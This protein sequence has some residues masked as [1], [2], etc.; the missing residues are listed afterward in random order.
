MFCG[1]KNVGP[2][3]IALSTVCP[4]NN[5][6]D[7]ASRERH[8]FT[9]VRCPIIVIVMILFLFHWYR[10]QDQNPWSKCSNRCPGRLTLG[11]DGSSE[12]ASR[13]DLDAKHFALIRTEKWKYNIYPFLLQGWWFGR[14]GRIQC[15]RDSVGLFQVRVQETIY[16][17]IGF[18]QQ[19][20]LIILFV[21]HCLHQTQEIPRQND[22]LISCPGISP[23]KSNTSSWKASPSNTNTFNS[24]W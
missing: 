19:L 5:W 17:K 9:L 20:G 21:N 15:Q 12:S 1:T 7:E 8:H 18:A 22:Y 4:P 24:R 16:N 3:A 6:R 13:L 23:W 11:E 2:R 10:K 14:E